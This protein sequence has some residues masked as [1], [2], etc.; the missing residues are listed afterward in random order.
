LLVL[1]DSTPC[2]VKKGTVT[3]SA[4]LDNHKFKLYENRSKHAR[5]IVHCD[6]QINVG[7]LTVLCQ[8]R[9]V[10]NMSSEQAEKKQ[11]IFQ[12]ESY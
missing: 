3:K 12:W 9:K 7:F 11:E 2:F 10:S 5:I 4:Y 6:Y 8:S 1:L